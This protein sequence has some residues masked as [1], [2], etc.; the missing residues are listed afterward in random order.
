MAQ[1]VD[2]PPKR[3]EEEEVRPARKEG[4]S[5][6]ARREA[7]LALWLLLPTAIVMIAVAAYP[8]LNAFWTSFTNAQFARGGE[9]EFVGLANYRQLLSVTVQELPPEVDEA[10]NIVRD[11]ETGEID[12]E[13][14]VRV[15]P[16][17]PYRY[18]EITTFNVGDSRYVIG[19]TDPIFLQGVWDTFV[20]TFWAVMLETLLGMGIALVV[21]ASFPGRGIMRAAMLVPWAIPT[22]VSARMWEWMFAADRRGFWNTVLDAVGLA[23]RNIA[24]LTNPDLQIPAMVF[25]DVWKTTPFMALLLLAGLQSIPEDMYEAAAIDGAGKIR[26]FFSITLPL[27]TPALVVALI[28]RTLDSLRVFDLFQVVFGQNRVSMASYNYVQLIQFQNAG[29]ASAV[30]AVI[31]VIILV[32]AIAYVQLVGIE[33]R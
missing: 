26:Q 2:V 5:S 17:E 6:L 8:L 22:V 19:A 10:G 15:L 9:P 31:F 4:Q 25:I 21:N 11:P 12:Y 3:E 30:G 7:R 20:F 18:R 13:T 33:E 1:Q 32:F 16:R 24:W 28:F 29:Y 23:D 14:P 27:L